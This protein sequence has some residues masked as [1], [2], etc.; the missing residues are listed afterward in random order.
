MVEKKRLDIDDFSCILCLRLFYD[1]ITTPCGHSFCQQCLERALDHNNKCPLCKSSLSDVSFYFSKNRKIYH[2]ETWFTMI[3]V[4]LAMVIYVSPWWFFLWVRNYTTVVI[5]DLLV[6][7]LDIINPFR[8]YN[9]IYYC[10]RLEFVTW[11]IL[12]VELQ[13]QFFKIFS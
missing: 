10:R 7:L 3:Y 13:N 8:K 1:P 5:F 9:T 6:R 2:R 11:I 4:W 12:L